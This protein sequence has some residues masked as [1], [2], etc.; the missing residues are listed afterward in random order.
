[1]GVAQTASQCCIE[2]EPNQ[3]PGETNLSQERLSRI[4]NPRAPGNDSV[5]SPRRPT[6]PDDGRS[7][8]EFDERDRV[9]RRPETRRSSGGAAYF[10]TWTAWDRYGAELEGVGRI[11]SLAAP[12]ATLDAVAWV[13]GGDGALDAVLVSL[14]VSQTHSTRVGMAWKL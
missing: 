5:R 7:D 8:S 9:L 12:A 4:A 13:D 11:G 3:E 10:R 2:V 14:R 1:M 6:G